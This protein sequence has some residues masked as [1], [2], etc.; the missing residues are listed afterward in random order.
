MSTRPRIEF[1]AEGRCSA[2]VWAERKKKID[3]SQRQKDLEKLL[4]SV[5]GT[6][7]YDC[8]VAVSGGKDG[9]Y[10]SHNLKNKYGM[11]QTRS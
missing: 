4:D 9:S 3:W 6:K 7:P 1:D 2:C 8:M 11:N 10:V 5:R